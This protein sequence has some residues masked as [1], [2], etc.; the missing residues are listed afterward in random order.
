M[1]EEIL[2]YWQLKTNEVKYYDSYGYLPLP[3]LISR[4]TAAG[5]AEEVLQIMEGLGI[6][7][8]EL[9]SAKTSRRQAA[10]EQAVFGRFT[11]GAAH[12]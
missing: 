11:A 7:R 12:P 6:S 3:G 5:L 9:R 8:T 4:E 1:C 2:R 10:P